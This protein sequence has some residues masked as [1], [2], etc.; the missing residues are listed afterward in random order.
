MPKKYSIIKNIINN[1]TNLTNYI[2]EKV[3]QLQNIIRNTIIS[4]KSN[5]IGEIF[6]NNDTVLSISVLLDLY[7]KTKEMD[8]QNIKGDNQKLLE[9]IQKINDK[10]L[11][12]ICGFG[13]K[14]FD[15]LLYILFAI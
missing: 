10:L 1:N 6:S 15:D 9:Q 13:T 4:I 5:K 14:S 8:L 2:N 12:I 7:E 11:M 3:Q